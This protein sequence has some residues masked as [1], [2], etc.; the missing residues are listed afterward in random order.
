MVISQVEGATWA[1]GGRRLKLATE[2]F[3]TT[4][5]LCCEGAKATRINREEIFSP[6]ANAIRVK[7]YQEALA[8]A[9]DTEFGLFAGIATTTLKHATHFQVPLPSGMG[10][11]GSAHRWGGLPS[12]V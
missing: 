6:M 1:E 8:T 2:R 5:M 3:Y 9:T 4:L 10:N 11:D 12:A 7:D